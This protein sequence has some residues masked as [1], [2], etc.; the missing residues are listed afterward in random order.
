MNNQEKTDLLNQ[1][2]QKIP[3]IQIQAE[4]AVSTNGKK[5]AAVLLP[6]T[7]HRDELVMLYTHRS[8]SIRR[9][10]G[11]VS[12]PGGMEEAADRSYMDTALRET[13]EEI[14]I[15]P[16]Q[17]EVFGRLPSLISTSGYPIHP[18][19]G[20]IHEMNGLRKNIEEV[21][22]IFCIPLS[23]LLVEEN[24]SQEDYR[25]SSGEVHKVWTFREYEGEKVWGLTAEITRR[26]IEK[27]K[28]I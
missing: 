27:L 26:F 16:Q 9:H 11:Q 12:F 21:E 10:R 28:Q 22:K 24:L 5:A 8:N 3:P 18:Y 2:K 19:V 23:W 25:G 20:Y 4:P 17:V 7:V 15:Q 6:L 1:I 14:G 13:Y